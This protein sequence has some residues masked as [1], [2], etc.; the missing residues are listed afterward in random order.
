MLIAFDYDQQQISVPPFL[1]PGAEIQQLYAKHYKLEQ[2][3]S[4]RISRRLSEHC[5]GD[6]NTWLIEVK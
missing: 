1:V 2:I 3:D 5:Q 4:Q 6:E